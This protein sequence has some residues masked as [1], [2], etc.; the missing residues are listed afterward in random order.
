M[1][2]LPCREPVP[3]GCMQLLSQLHW[4]LLEAVLVALTLLTKWCHTLVNAWF[5]LFAL[6]CCLPPQHLHLHSPLFVLFE[7]LNI[8]K[9]LLFGDHHHAWTWLAQAFAVLYF[10]HQETSKDSIGFF[11]HKAG[12]S[13]YHGRFFIP[14]CACVYVPCKLNRFRQIW[15]RYDRDE[16]I[17]R[18]KLDW[19]ST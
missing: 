13:W 8:N 17:R 12:S 9:I 11:L 15:D 3:L 2:Y 19:G 18:P 7:F 5:E 1:E 6:E 4:S 10:S 16:S 14:T